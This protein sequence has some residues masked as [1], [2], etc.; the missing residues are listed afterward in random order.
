MDAIE[1][2]DDI[3]W[4]LDPF[5]RF[6]RTTPRIARLITSHDY[7]RGDACA[8]RAVRALCLEFIDIFSTAVRSLLA[9]VEPMVIEINRSEKRRA[10]GFPN[11][12]ISYKN[13]EPFVVKLTL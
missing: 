5:E 9:K 6:D 3:E 8:P 4:K 7:V 2:D 1:H 10:T 11:K 13:N 12:T